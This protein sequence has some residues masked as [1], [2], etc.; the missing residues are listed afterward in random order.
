MAERKNP[1]TQV[2]F[3]KYEG[4]HRMP[5]QLKDRAITHEINR[6]RVVG[7]ILLDLHIMSAVGI[8]PKG[9]PISL[10]GA[11]MQNLEGSGE[12]MTQAAHCAPRQLYI[13]AET[14]QWFLRKTF[15]ERAWAMEILF[16]ETDILPA[17]FNV[18]DSRAERYGLNEAF[19][20]ACQYV[21]SAGHQ[22]SK[23]DINVIV[24]KTDNAFSIYR[25]RAAQAYRQSIE[26]LQSNLRPK[27][28]FPKE[29]AKWTEQLQITEQYAET[30]RESPGREAGISRRKSEGLLKEYKLNQAGDDGM[31]DEG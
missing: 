25:E 12:R 28:L 9:L 6:Q 16:A 29:R 1:F 13:G 8:I 5:F 3:A 4:I 21:I 7:S 2:G 22:D 14:P 31:R 30:L 24:I 23:P 20:E 15:P 19:R 26:K 11:V 27:Y 18:C 17:G 10:R